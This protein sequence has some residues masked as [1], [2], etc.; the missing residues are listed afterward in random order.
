MAILISTFIAFLNATGVVLNKIVL[1]RQKVGH[2]PFIVT[3]FFLLAFF[4]LLV[5]PFLGRI[6]G[7]VLSRYL[8]L[9]IL[10]IVIASVY[11]VLYYHA[12][13]KEK[14]VEWE[15]IV[16]FSPLVTILFAS[17][18]LQVE[19]NLHVIFAGLV[20]SGALVLSHFRRHHLQF[21][22]FQ[23]GLFLYLFLYALEAV[24]IRI[25]LNVYSPVALY[26]FRTAG[27]FL[28]LFLWYLFLAPRFHGE[29]PLTFH[30]WENKHFGWV[31]LISAL[32]VIQMV[33]IYY[34][35]AG[36][37]I[38]YTTT[39]LT[40]SPILTYLAGVVILKERIKKRMILVAAIILSCIVYANLAMLR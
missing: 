16:M 5:Y 7:P 2:R 33:L 28:C 39:V 15:L 36:Y 34:A 8:G 24:L 21:D 26:F 38:V 31:A 20:A 4:T 35:Y 18:F 23:K 17:L 37:G 9:L 14:L 3:L 32:A 1:S 29:P 22:I 13:E 27:V 19:R 25:L 30:Q 6:E 40:F 11:N 10:V 12:L